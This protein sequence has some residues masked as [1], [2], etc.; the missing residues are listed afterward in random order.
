MFLSRTSELRQYPPGRSFVA[1]A[2]QAVTRAGEVVMD[3]AY[4]TAREDKP[5][6][7][8]RQQVRCADVYVGIIGFR[9]GSPV[10]DDPR[11]SHTELEL[12][13]ATEHGLPRLVFLLEEEAV[14]PLPQ[15]YLF[16]PLYG[17]RQ[18]A[19]RAQLMDAG[20]TVQR[21]ESP[22]RLETLLF[23][24]LGRLRGSDRQN[25]VDASSAGDTDVGE[26]GHHL[27]A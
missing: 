7:Y 20:I 22:D 9:Y 18:R 19:F 16:D 1:A 13:A 3:M 4:F 17:D 25:V 15:N 6:D 23:H 12:Q 2:E 24:A 14:L 26:Q 8:C 11:R 27:Q 10:R 5:A 21:V